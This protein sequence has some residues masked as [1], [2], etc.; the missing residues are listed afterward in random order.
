MVRANL[1]QGLGSCRKRRVMTAVAAAVLAGLL[2]V[3]AAAASQARKT[4]TG[5]RAAPPARG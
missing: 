2:A 5:R 3:P 4:P 1:L